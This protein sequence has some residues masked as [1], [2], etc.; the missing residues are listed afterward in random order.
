M[1]SGMS[2]IQLAHV[3]VEILLNKV[4]GLREWHY[5]DVETEDF[6]VVK[7]GGEKEEYPSFFESIEVNQ[8][9][10]QWEWSADKAAYPSTRELLKGL[11]AVFARR[12][13]VTAKAFRR[14]F[15]LG[16]V[17]NQSG[18][19][20]GKLGEMNAEEHARRAIVFEKLLRSG[21]CRQRFMVWLRGTRGF[22]FHMYRLASG[23]SSCV[24]ILF[25]TLLITL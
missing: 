18:A 17:P 5:F 14:I 24:W 20:T 15:D 1:P 4:V 25:V 16:V 6:E 23:N 10:S 13:E 8:S 12:P 19:F 7:A 9:T 11:F 22:S 2:E 3:A 21:K